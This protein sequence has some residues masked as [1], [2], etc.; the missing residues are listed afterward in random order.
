MANQLGAAPS[1]EAAEKAQLALECVDMLVAH[2]YPR[3][4]VAEI[5]IYERVVGGLVFCLQSEELTSVD[6]D[7]LF[8][9]VASVKERVRVAE[10]ICDSFNTALQSYTQATNS[11][12]TLNLSVHELQG[13]NYEKLR[14]VVA[15]L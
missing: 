8:R 3:A 14:Q 1:A 4:S 11:K 6:C 7:I 13:P 2:G 9:P 15:W 12:T 10:A 5:P